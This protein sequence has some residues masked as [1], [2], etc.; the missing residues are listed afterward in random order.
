[1]QRLKK[2]PHSSLEW[3]QIRHRDELGK[4]TF[5][6]SEAGTLMSVSPYQNLM[7][8]CLAK[9]DEPVLRP[10]SAAMRK[11]IIF[12]DALGMEAGEILGVEVSQ[13]DEM[14][15]KGRFTTTLDFMNAK[16]DL[17]VE[18]K[19]TNQ[20][21]INTGEDLP[22]SWLMQGHVQH[23][24]TGADVWFSVFDKYHQIS[25]VRMPVSNETIDRLLETSEFVGEQ[26]DRGIIPDEAWMQASSEQIAKAYPFD[27]DEI[28]EC[29]DDLLADIRELQT[30][31]AQGKDVEER[32]KALKARIAL[33]MKSAKAI[34]SNGDILL[35]WNEQKGRTSLDQKALQEAHPDIYNQF[36]KQ[37]API[38]VMRMGK[39]L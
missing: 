9:L 39:A 7:D 2:P 6:A 20:Y 31:K 3:L 29:D 22:P 24:V 30:V 15:R 23:W 38:R 17:I 4:V 33:R 32:E 18:C 11:G 1:M 37:G 25:V 14:F 10:P 12:E 13:P 27:S 19:V 35:T 28:V 8:L 26:L 5:G 21:T 34:E 16:E 36:M